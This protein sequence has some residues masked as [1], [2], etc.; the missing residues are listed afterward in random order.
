MGGGL[1]LFNLSPDVSEVFTVTRL[2]ALLGICREQA[3]PPAS[4]PEQ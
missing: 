1:T 4:L 3:A 2:Q